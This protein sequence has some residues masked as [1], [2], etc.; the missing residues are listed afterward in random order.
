MH[1]RTALAAAATLLAASLPAAANPAQIKANLAKLLTGSP[2]IDQVQESPIPGLWAVRIG[3]Q[4]IYTNPTGT[5]VVE[6]QMVELKDRRNLTQE[7]ISAALS[8]PFDKLP[9]KDAIVTYRHGAGER[10]LA[11]FSDPM[12]PY[13]RR[14]E[15]NLRELQNVTVYTFVI[16]VL[17]AKSESIT[18]SVICSADPAKAWADWMMKSV[19][20]APAPAG[21]D[22]SSVDRNKAFAVA[23]HL[24]STPTTYFAD[25]TRVAGDMPLE[26]L[27]RRLDAA[28]R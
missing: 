23:Y 17:G 15:N 11:V 9:I 20:P 12:C 14:I 6:G 2:K 4:I 18:K 1:I 7:A 25:G 26:Q 5:I 10:K 13:C 24:N 19:Q 21:C 16:P 22:T 3:S 28:R 8:L 27:N